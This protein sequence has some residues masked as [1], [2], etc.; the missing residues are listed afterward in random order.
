MTEPIKLFND[1][2]HP[3]HSS[4]SSVN[5]RSPFWISSIN[6]WPSS[7]ATFILRPL[8]APGG[9]FGFFFYRKFI[10][11]LLKHCEIWKKGHVALRA[12]PTSQNL[13]IPREIA[14]NVKSCSK[15]DK[16][17]KSFLQGRREPWERGCLENTQ[18]FI[19]CHLPWKCCGK[20]SF[21]VKWGRQ[22]YTTL[23]RVFKIAFSWFGSHEYVFE[24]PPSFV[25]YEGRFFVDFAQ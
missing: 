1:L 21:S 2:L 16:F 4:L 18:N 7:P 24:R 14:Q 3:R 5:L 10:N 20:R 23:Q 17:P 25:R 19:G 6:R 13:K 15:Y 12:A 8:S 11:C 9:K 22:A